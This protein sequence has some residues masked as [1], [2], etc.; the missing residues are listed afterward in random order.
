MKVLLC[1]IGTQIQ[2]ALLTLSA[3]TSTSHLNDLQSCLFFVMR[4]LQAIAFPARNHDDIAR[5]AI[6]SAL[7]WRDMDRV[8]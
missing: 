6:G 7:L 4:R 8:V 1:R 3:C 5:S 2:I